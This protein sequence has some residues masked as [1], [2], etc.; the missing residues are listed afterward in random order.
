MDRELKTIPEF[1]NYAITKD[2][3][4]WSKSRERKGIGVFKTR[5]YQ[6]RWLNPVNIKDYLHVDLCSDGKIFHAR[7]NRLMLETYVGPC[8]A[9]MEACHNN[10]I[11]TDNRL[12]NL[13]WDTHKANQ[14]DMI[15]HGHTLL[16]SK[17]PMT[18]L[19]ADKVN[20]LRYLRH[21]V[22]FSLN[23]IAWQFDVSIPSVSAIC[24]GRNWRPV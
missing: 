1:P 2:G 21:V 13:R 18:K 15:K 5:F 9:G 20:V 22:K 24:T 12:E 4:V 11:R 8:P 3:R 7:L 23:D 10:G 17:N 14:Q 16:G 6:G 19:T